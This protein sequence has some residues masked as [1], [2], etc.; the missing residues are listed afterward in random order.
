MANQKNNR[1]IDSPLNGKKSNVIR[2]NEPGHITGGSSSA[3]NYK[4]ACFSF[5]GK[6]ISGDGRFLISFKDEDNL[7]KST[8]IIKLK[9]TWTRFSINLKADIELK[10]VEWK[11]EYLGE[12]TI[13]FSFDLPQIERGLRPTSYIPEGTR[14]R[15]VMYY[16]LEKENLQLVPTATIVCE[17]QTSNHSKELIENELRTIL[18]FEIDSE[19][20][21][22][23]GFDGNH[24]GSLSIV[25]RAGDKF[26]SIKLGYNIN[27]DE[28][29]LLV[30]TY[31]KDE[32]YIYING[33]PVWKSKPI[34]KSNPKKLFIGSVSDETYKKGYK[35]Y[36]L[37]GHVKNFMIYEKYFF[38]DEIVGLNKFFDKESPIK[39]RT[40]SSDLIA[41]YIGEGEKF[42]LNELE[43]VL[44]S[45]LSYLKKGTIEDVIRDTFS[46]LFEGRGSTITREQHKGIGR[47]DLLIEYDKTSNLFTQNKFRIEF[48]IWGRTGYKKAPS[49]PIK[50]MGLGE[51]I[52]VFIMFDYSVKDKFQRMKEFFKTNEKYPQV[53]CAEINSKNLFNYNLKAFISEHESPINS[54]NVAVIGIY[55]G[56][57]D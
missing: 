42:F 9:K 57:R 33:A 2:L 39:G 30:L 46:M 4:T 55:I 3:I 50:Y 48:K 45:S 40:R 20:E 11:I 54:H 17:F 12:S 34:V 53:E 38:H 15:D 1:V 27:E 32:S 43:N 26:D 24:N 56:I 5:Y 29:I 41:N 22:I 6:L 16:D 10:K 49:Q 18:S 21:I 19:N 14:D 36:S 51:K 47:T 35:E 25:T 8:K 31:D 44:N 28:L 13:E 7:C 52:G 37:N 23:I